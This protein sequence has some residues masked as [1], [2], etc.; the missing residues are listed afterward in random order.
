MLSARTLNGS[1]S[2]DGVEQALG[3]GFAA[4][5]HVEHA[6][7]D[8]GIGADGVGGGG[9][10]EGSFG[11]VILAAVGKSFGQGGIKGRGPGIVR[12][13][14]QLG[15]GRSHGIDQQPARSRQPRQGV[16]I[17]GVFGHGLQGRGLG[18][19]KSLVGDIEIGQ[20]HER[21]SVVRV[22]RKGLLSFGSA[23]GKSIALQVG[24]AQASPSPREK[25]G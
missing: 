23:R 16:F 24:L 4:Y 18:V 21:R 7:A 17:A 10:Q 11:R 1:A 9:E 20:Q 12:Q 13:G 2:N 25:A 22:D 14:G 19:D 6:Q 8:R 5:L 3:L 15:G